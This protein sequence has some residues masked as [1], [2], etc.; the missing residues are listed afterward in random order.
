ML[1]LNLKCDFR[2]IVLEKICLRKET[3][4]LHVPINQ[5]SERRC[6][7]CKSINF[8][9]RKKHFIIIIIYRFLRSLQKKTLIPTVFKKKLKAFLT[10]VTKNV[11]NF[12][13]NN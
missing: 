7:T 3:E 13:N 1:I 11:I 4:N 5:Y 9:N 2:F 8:E 6:F 12:S 10:N